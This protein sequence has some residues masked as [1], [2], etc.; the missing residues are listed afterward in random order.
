MSAP[1]LLAISQSEQPGAATGTGESA[2]YSATSYV[3]FSIIASAALSVCCRSPTRAPIR[4]KAAGPRCG[5]ACV[6]QCR[7][8][9]R[10]RDGV[11]LCELHFCRSPVFA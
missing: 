6:S 3:S 10:R 5:L 7:R 1:S 4:P 9:R 11:G 8:R 2:S